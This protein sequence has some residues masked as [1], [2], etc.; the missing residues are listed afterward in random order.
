MRWDETRRRRKRQLEIR[1]DKV[2]K[3]KEMKTEMGC[4]KI[5]HVETKWE[6][7]RPTESKWD[8]RSD[9]IRQTKT[10]LKEMRTGTLAHFE[11][12]SKQQKK[13][14]RKEKIWDKLK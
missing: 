2:I 1:K 8:K 4:G 6:K 5:M 10:R 9:K 11:T 7:R 14:K 3:E 12:K 13:R